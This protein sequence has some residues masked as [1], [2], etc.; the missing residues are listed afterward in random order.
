MSLDT[1]V[2]C[3]GQSRRVRRQR[4]FPRPRRQCQ[5]RTSQRAAE[6][7]NLQAG[8]DRLRYQHPAYRR[9]QMRRLVKR[10]DRS[11]NLTAAA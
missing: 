5:E 11:P 8:R 4:R 1:F 9:A 2:Y 7:R 10:H 3:L 6:Y